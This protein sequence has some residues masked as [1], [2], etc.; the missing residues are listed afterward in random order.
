MWPGTPSFDLPTL[1]F[2]GSS[3]LISVPG[4]V[5]GT[6]IFTVPA[7]QDR[8]AT[9]LLCGSKLLELGP[10]SDNNSGSREISLPR[11]RTS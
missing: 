3:S 6:E 11:G 8:K 2:A 7:S 1:N 9:S 10:H 4:F 5:P